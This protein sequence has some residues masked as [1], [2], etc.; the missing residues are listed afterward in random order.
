LEL[1][2]EDVEETGKA[3]AAAAATEAAKRLG[4]FIGM[5][6]CLEFKSLEFCRG[7]EIGKW[8]LGES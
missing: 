6:I 8:F 3:E 4:F 2:L 7:Q 5:V 1:Q